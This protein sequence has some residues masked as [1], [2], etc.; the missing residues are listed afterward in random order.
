MADENEAVS[1]GSKTSNLSFDEFVDAALGAA[2][3]AT[4]KHVPNAKPG[5]LPFPIWVGIIAGPFDQ[6]KF[7]GGGQG[8]G[9]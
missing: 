1:P 8:G 3:R 4:A 9:I 7:G 6:G 5:H 2:I